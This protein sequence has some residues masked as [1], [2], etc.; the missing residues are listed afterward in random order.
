MKRTTI[1]SIVFWVLFIGSFGLYKR[2]PLVDTVWVFVGRLCILA[3]AVFTLVKA[4]LDHGKTRAFSY[5]GYPRW[6]ERF[7]MDEEDRPRKQNR[8]QNKVP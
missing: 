8:K 1:A 4:Y 2:Y 6:L 7:L 5:Q 3:L